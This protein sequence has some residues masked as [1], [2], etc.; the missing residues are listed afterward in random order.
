MRRIPMLSARGGRLRLLPW[1]AGLVGISCLSVLAQKPPQNSPD[2]ESAKYVGAEVCQGCHE[3][4]YKSFAKSAHAETLKSK[5]AAS[6]GCEGCHGP[7]AEHVETGGDP[8][9]IWTYAGAAPRTILARCNSCHQAH[10][11]KAD[12]EAHPHCLTCHSA[13][14]YKQE[15]FLLVRSAT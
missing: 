14:H 2:P 9:R 8:S 3:E 6:R 5:K 10:R 1:L 4:A 11:D 13:H 15:K 12:A 7:G